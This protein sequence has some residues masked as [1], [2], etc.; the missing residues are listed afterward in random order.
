MQQYLSVLGL[1]LIVAGLVLALL[2]VILLQRS[3][4]P[5]GSGGVVIFIGPIPILMGSDKRVTLIMLTFAILL[6]FVFVIEYLGA[7]L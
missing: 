3:G 7:G 5:K 4:G 6:V 2:S 1:I